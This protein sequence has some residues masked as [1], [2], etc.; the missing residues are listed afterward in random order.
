M[1][2]GGAQPAL[3]ISGLRKTYKGHLSLTSREVV[4]GLDLSVEA[5]QVFGLLGQNGAGKTTT[6]KM[7]LSLIFPDA[8][9]IR[10]LGKDHLDVS[11]RARI[12]FLPENPYFYDYLTGREFLDFYGR[13]FGYGR[14]ERRQRSED[15]LAKVRMSEHGDMQLRKYSKGMLQRIGM[16]QALLN[17]PDLI[18]LDEPTNG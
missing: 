12:G 6:I 13:L 15:V 17:D 9:T 14:S 10:L 3:E 16:A 4:R 2:T 5:S 7:I 18:I 1:T 8:G 11:V